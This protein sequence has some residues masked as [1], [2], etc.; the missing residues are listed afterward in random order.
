MHLNSNTHSKCCFDAK[1]H[2]HQIICRTS[3]VQGQFTLMVCQTQPATRTSATGT[4]FRSFLQCELLALLVPLHVQAEVWLPS[5][6]HHLVDGIGPVHDQQTQVWHWPNK[7][8]IKIHVV[9]QIVCCCTNSAL[10]RL[11]MSPLKIFRSCPS[12]LDVNN[13]CFRRVHPTLVVKCDGWGNPKSMFA[14]ETKTRVDKN[15]LNQ[16]SLSMFVRV[17]NL[18][19]RMR[20]GTRNGPPMRTGKAT[21]HCFGPFCALIVLF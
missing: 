2:C 21:E 14:K 4:C 15:C 6:P 1:L 8:H 3:A 10:P 9:Y 13:F 16:H 18:S 7:Q 12:N 5:K 17:S 19:I 11:S 20:Q